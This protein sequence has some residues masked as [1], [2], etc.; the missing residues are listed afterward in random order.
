MRFLGNIEAKIDSKGRVF[1]PAS[2]R[3]ELQAAGEESLVVRKDVFQPCLVLYPE[4]VW[5]RQMDTL[6]SRLNRWNPMRQNVF[7]QFVADAETVT[8]DA[9]GRFT[10]GRQHVK[11]A[12]AAQAVRFI[13][14]DDVI[15][16]WG[17][18]Q[19]AAPFMG[20]EEFGKALES[21]MKHG[22]DGAQA[23]SCAAPSGNQ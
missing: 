17:A 2:F 5:N 9:N 20:Q 3:K 12:G 23:D 13:G 15:E 21:I 22:G 11:M 7:R 19:S 4:S 1:L 14:M 18:E 8:L 16:I 10:L 6:R